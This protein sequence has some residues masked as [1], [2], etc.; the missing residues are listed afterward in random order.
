[1]RMSLGCVRQLNILRRPI[2]LSEWIIHNQNSS[3]HWTSSYIYMRPIYIFDQYPLRN[4]FIF[5]IEKRDKS[6]LLLANRCLNDVF[7]RLKL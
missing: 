4:F 7:V 2:Y 1:M 3:T 5:L 6:T